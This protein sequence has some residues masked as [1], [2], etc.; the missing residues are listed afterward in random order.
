MLRHAWQPEEVGDAAQCQHQ[1]IIPDGEERAHVAVAGDD[2]ALLQVHL[3][4]L[5]LA[6]H[7]PPEKGAQ[8]RDDVLGLDRPRGHLREQGREEREVLCVHEHDLDARVPSEELLQPQGGGGT[9]EPVPRITIR[10]GSAV[11]RVAS[12]TTC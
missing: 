11:I 3:L 7:R 10:V 9:G 1:M 5:R 4:D 6:D 2:R 12:V 8:G